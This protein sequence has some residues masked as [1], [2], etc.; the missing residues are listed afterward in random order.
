MDEYLKFLE[1]FRDAL[2]LRYDLNRAKK[3]DSWKDCPRQ[4]LID[5]FEEEV[6]E[7]RKA[8]NNP[9]APLSRIHHELEDVAVVSAM[10]WV[11]E[12]DRVL[13]KYAAMLPEDF[14]PDPLKR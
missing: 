10:I 3:G 6:A 5:K 7:A 8:L 11:R 12:R 13:D 1:E 4:F 14:S 2:A 9:D